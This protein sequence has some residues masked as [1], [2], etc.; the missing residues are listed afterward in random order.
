MPTDETWTLQVDTL[1][2]AIGEQQDGEA[3]AA[4]GIPL[5]D[6]GWPEVNAD[7]ESRLANVFLIGDV[8][9]GPSSI[10]SAIG[11]ARR[12]SDAILKRENIR[13]HFGDKQWNNV[14]PADIYRRKGTIAIAQVDKDDRDAFVAQ[15]AERCLECNYVCSKC[16]DVC[17]NRANV[18]IAVPGFENRFQTLHLDAYCNECGNCAQFC[19]WQGKPYKDKGHRF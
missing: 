4:M 3:L 17:P 2:T 14:D 10:V 8:Q 5:N 9:R 11:N 6:R 12:A 18:S 15:E 1:I 16:V 13:S 19:P 7:G